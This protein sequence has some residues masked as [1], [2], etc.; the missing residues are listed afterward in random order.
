[1]RKNSFYILSIVTILIGCD[2]KSDNLY[3]INS[4][5]KVDDFEQKRKVFYK[6]GHLKVAVDRLNGSD[7]GNRYEFYETGVLKQYSFQVDSINSTY[8]VQFDSVGKIRS[9][10]GKPLVYQFLSAD[11]APDS[12]YVKY[13]ISDFLNQKN[14]LF[15]SDNGIEFYQIKTKLD[16]RLAFISI[17]EYW[18]NVKNA[19]RIFIVSKLQS[20]SDR[21]GGQIYIDTIDLSRNKK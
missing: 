18:K 6:N 16:N 5:T 12:F 13:Y 14:S 7:F 3:N 1:M 20:L 21:S 15:L 10:V 9:V 17:G 19:D 2:R 11:E 8:V 4:L